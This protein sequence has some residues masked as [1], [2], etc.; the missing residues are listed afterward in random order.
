[1]KQEDLKAWRAYAAAAITGIVASKSRV[2]SSAIAAKA[3]DVADEMLA[4]DRERRAEDD[5]G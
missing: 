3:A 4:I 1:M 5:K 2:S